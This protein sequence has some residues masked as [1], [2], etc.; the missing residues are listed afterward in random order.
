MAMF[1]WY[2]ELMQDFGDNLRSTGNTLKYYEIDTIK[3][4]QEEF[5]INNNKIA[6]YIDYII[7]YYSKNA[8]NK[9]LFVVDSFRNPMCIK[10]LR[11]RYPGF[12]LISLFASK[13]ERKRRLLEKETKKNNSTF[14]IEKFKKYFENDDIRDSGEGLKNIES[15]FKQNVS[16]TVLIS[17][18]AINNEGIAKNQLFEKS[19]RYL[20]LIADPGCT[21]PTGTEMFMNI[22]YT[23]AMKSNCISRK[24]GAVIE[25]KKG[26]VIGAGWN[27]VG[28][29][30]ISC[31][32]R[33][34][35]DLKLIEYSDYIDAI[36]N[37]AKDLDLDKDE[38]IKYLI[39]EYGDEN[40]CF[41]FKDVISHFEMKSKIDRTKINNNKENSDEKLMIEN[42]NKIKVKKLEYCKALHA[43]ENAIIQS[44]KI[45]GM[46]LLDARIY[47]T[48]FPC[49]LCAKKIQQSGINEV[50]YVEPYPESISEEL[51][52]KDGV[53]KVKTTQFEGVKAYS[54]FKLFK[55]FF[56]QKEKQ[57][58]KK[59]G[60]QMNII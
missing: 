24:V 5:Q 1:E 48:T 12:F 43:E 21:K 29:G 27:D 23:M 17:D 8:P 47:V 60:F 10:Y 42:Q 3:E 51:Y 52:L 4:N 44:A 7:N 15:F 20:A 40:S 55:P 46:G 34:I 45:G 36:R 57:D 16:E 50:I 32:L 14:D 54:Y 19:L 26:Y 31:G 25:G 49:E 18:I 53:R 37:K 30:Q 56:N 41:C 6:K 2:R 58:Y 33:N 39:S 35:K 59:N 9:H 38:I 13:N 28:V 11:K 22:A